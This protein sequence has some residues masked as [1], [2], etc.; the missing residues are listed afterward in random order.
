[1]RQFYP[2]SC[3]PLWAFL[4]FKL[5]ALPFAQTFEA[6]ALYRRM[7]HEHVFAAILRGNEA[8]SFSIAK[9]FYCTSAHKNQPLKKDRDNRVKL[10]AFYYPFFG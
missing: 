10:H 9:P 2:A 1:M 7:M 3:L 8:E 5:H 6:R 4:R